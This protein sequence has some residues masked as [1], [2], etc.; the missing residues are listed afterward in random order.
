MAAQVILVHLVHVRVVVSQLLFYIPFLHNVFLLRDLKIP[1]LSLSAGA[2]NFRQPGG[3]KRLPARGAGC[4][5]PVN[6]NK[7]EDT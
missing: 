1:T 5:R 7:L 6:N 2:Q 4:W 3:N